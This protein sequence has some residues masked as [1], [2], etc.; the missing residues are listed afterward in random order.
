MRT[1]FPKLV[2]T[3]GLAVAAACSN[4]GSPDEQRVQF[5]AKKVR[6]GVATI[7]QVNANP[8]LRSFRWLGGQVPSTSAVPSTGA[9]RLVGLIRDIAGM[10]SPASGPAAIPVIRSSML[11]KTMVYDAV[12]KKYVIAE[13][14]T[15]APSNGVRFVLYESGA[16]GQPDVA[17]EIGYSD[18]TDEKAASATTAGLRFRVVSAGKTYLDYS[19]DLTGSIGAVTVTVKGF[20]SDG[21]ERVNFDLATTGQLFGR[22]G[23]VTLDAK[24]DV[25]S[26]QFSVTAKIVGSAGEGQQPGQVELTVK[27]GADVLAINAK[28]AAGQVDAAVT[29]NAKVFAT[30]KGDPANPVIKG[31]GGREL[32]ADEMAALGKVFEFS[33]GIFE[34]IGGLLAPA[35]A[36]LLLGLGI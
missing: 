5:D 33:K 35:G 23:T 15:G 2:A 13:G 8:V 22:G 1:Q 21:T 34:L 27:A 30:I 9:D 28:F 17:K 25:P 36:L 32:T 11:G 4:P 20:M 16:D 18:L 10:V 24:L 19:F 31:E 12:A 6:D 29:V 7:E 3:M 26:Q 14:R